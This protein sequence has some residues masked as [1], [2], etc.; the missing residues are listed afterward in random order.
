MLLKCGRMGGMNGKSYILI[1]Y[2][3]KMFSAMGKLIVVHVNCLLD[4]YFNTAFIMKM[5]ALL[6]ETL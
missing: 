4:S 6:T 2:L 1:F 5:G 3:Y